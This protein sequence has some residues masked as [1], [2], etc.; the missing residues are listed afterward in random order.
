LAFKTHYNPLTTPVENIRKFKLDPS[1]GWKEKD[2]IMPPPFFTNQSLPLSWNWQPDPYVE[3]E[4]QQHST[5]SNPTA[6][7]SRRKNYNPKMNFIHHD[8][9]CPPE[10]PSNVSQAKGL[11]AMISALEEAFSE[12]PIWTREALAIRVSHSAYITLLR[13]ALQHLAYRFKAGPWRDCFI[14][15]G[16]DPRRDPKYRAYQTIFFRVHDKDQ[17]KKKWYQP[18]LVPNTYD[19]AKSAIQTFDGKS[20]TPGNKIWQMCDISD[21]LL[22]RLIKTAPYRELCDNACDGWFTNGA[23]AKIRSI[24]RTKLDAIQL[25]KEVADDEFTVTLESPDVVLTKRDHR[26]IVVPLPNIYPKDD[27]IF[28]MSE[29]GIHLIRTGARKATMAKGP[30]RSRNRVALRPTIN[31]YEDSDDDELLQQPEFSQILTNTGNNNDTNQGTST[32]TATNGDTYMAE[33]EQRGDVSV[34]KWLSNASN[35][36]F[37]DSFYGAEEDNSDTGRSAPDS[38]DEEDFDENAPGVDY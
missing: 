17:G 5:N 32:A 25:G 11:R 3:A 28:K 8:A 31:T 36:I 38:E 23:L 14:K 4:P 35:E 26:E 10:L 29:R 33:N 24:M 34:A 9:D 7:R 16:L 22:D 20:F 13:K 15:R 2:E 12:R 18:S 1:R 30:L 19:H 27:E 21:P 37:A 6:V